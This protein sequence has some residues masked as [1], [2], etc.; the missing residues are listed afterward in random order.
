MKKKKNDM[1]SYNIPEN[2]FDSLRSFF[3]AKGF[4]EQQF[5]DQMIK[6][7][8]LI[9]ASAFA[10]LIKQKPP[11][12]PLHSESEATAFIKANFSE[13]DIETAMQEEGRSLVTEYFKNFGVGEVNSKEGS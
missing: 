5:E 6:L 4:S 11:E 1:T 2:L 13:E 8:E 3:I 9:V 10:R 12:Y 7:G